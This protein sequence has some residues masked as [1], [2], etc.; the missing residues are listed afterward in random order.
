VPAEDGWAVVGYTAN[1]LGRYSCFLDDDGTAWIMW[2][3]NYARILALGYREDG[4]FG[5]LWNG[6]ARREVRPLRGTGS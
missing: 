4:D 3:T 5:E 1:E 6:W 2:T